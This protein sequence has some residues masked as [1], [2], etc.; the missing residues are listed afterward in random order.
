M[1]RVEVVD[2]F[3][4]VVV[5]DSQEPDDDAWERQGVEDGVKQLHVDAS[6]AAADTVQEYRCGIHTG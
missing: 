5:E 2:P 3:L 6:E 4:V 1:Q